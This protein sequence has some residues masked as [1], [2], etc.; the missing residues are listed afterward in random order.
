MDTRTSIELILGTSAPDYPP[1][2]L[3]ISG[4][5]YEGFTADYAGLLGKTT[6]L[7]VT[8]QRFASREAAI[9]AL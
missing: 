6:G 8:V 9:D 2:D 7:P 4:H 3:T 5:D 1:F